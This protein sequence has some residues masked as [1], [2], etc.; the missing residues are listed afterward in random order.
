MICDP[1]RDLVRLRLAQDSNLWPLVFFAPTG[2][3]YLG[4][5]SLASNPLAPVDRAKCRGRLSDRPDGDDVGIHGRIL[6]AEIAKT[7]SAF[8]VIYTIGRV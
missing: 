4:Q 3:L 8:V 5:C 7:N 2:S 6:A 1:R